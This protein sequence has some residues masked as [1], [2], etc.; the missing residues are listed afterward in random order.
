MNFPVVAVAGTS[1]GLAQGIRCFLVYSGTIYTVQPFVIS[2]FL[3]TK[4][5]PSSLSIP[6][7]K[8]IQTLQPLPMGEKKELPPYVFSVQLLKDLF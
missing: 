2:Y 7:Y 1:S 3:S 6:A 5:I 8:L 4:I